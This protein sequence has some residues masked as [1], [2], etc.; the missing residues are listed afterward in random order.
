[1]PLPKSK[2]RITLSEVGSP[3]Y[4]VDIRL[5]Q[6]MKYSDVKILFGDER[7]LTRPDSEYVE[8]MFEKMVIEWNIPEEEGGP[9]M[10]VPAQD[11]QSVGKLPNTFV[12]FI[13]TKMTEDMGH[14]L[15]DTSDL[16]ETS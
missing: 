1:M 3:E 7:D 11:M 8:D 16:G 6:G 13:I 14:D 12:N 10:P 4:W 9:I 15:P 2:T 5:L